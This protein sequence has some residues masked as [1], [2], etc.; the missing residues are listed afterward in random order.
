MKNDVAALWGEPQRQAPAGIIIIIVKGVVRI[1]KLLWPILLIVVFRGKERDSSTLE[2]ILAVAPILILLN[3]ILE[4]YYF[5]FFIQNDHLIIR[6]GF[7]KK[8]EI[9]IPISK[10]H[11]VNIDQNFL[12]QLLHVVK[13]KIDTAGSD[14]TEAVIDAIDKNRAESLK[15]LLLSNN[16]ENEGVETTQVFDDDVL[17]HSL[18][19]KELF[20]LGVSANHL[21][22][23]TIILA[24]AVSLIQNL[25]EIFG[26]RVVNYIRESY[27]GVIHSIN[28]I[29]VLIVSL[30]AISILVSFVRILFKYGNFKVSSNVGGLKVLNGLIE[31]RE[32]IVPFDKIQFLSY[33]STYI[34]RKI[35]L[36]YLRYHQ[37]KTEEK[38]KMPRQRLPITESAVLSP[39]VNFYNSEIIGTDSSEHR[40]HFSFVFRMTLVQGL[41]FAILFSILFSFGLGL[42]ALYFMLII[43][44]VFVTAAVYRNNYRLMFHREGVE[45]RSGVWG[46]KLELL[47]WKNIQ[48]IDIIQS[49]F[50]RRSGIASC[51]IKTA[52]GN[53]RLR[54]IKREV[55]F[56]LLN[57]GLYRVEKE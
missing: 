46:R 36:G 16:E 45:I 22:A 41:P 17:I 15:E 8:K 37:A 31:R 44:Y 12:Q 49:Y 21:Q 26:N 42:S 25:D 2:I 9:S 13:L 53:I 18:S 33:S 38:A 7:I 23:F 47:Q 43:P 34:G 28:L 19:P 29:L 32:S 1:I 50:Q 3:S 35:G 5:Y 51:V 6:R 14:S 57:Y 39:L 24:F 20:Y 4:Y 48:Q 52:G 30:L 40:L 55:A 56:A 27:Y 10:I 11:A 54:F